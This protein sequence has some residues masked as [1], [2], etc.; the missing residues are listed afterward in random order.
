[1]HIIESSLF[2]SPLVHDLRLE[3]PG[4]EDLDKLLINTL[5]EVPSQCYI[6]FHYCVLLSLTAVSMVGE[7]FFFLMYLIL[8]SILIDTFDSIVF[9]L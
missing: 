9:F 4:V 3:N 7:G 1:M 5:F 2:S 8:Y 6:L